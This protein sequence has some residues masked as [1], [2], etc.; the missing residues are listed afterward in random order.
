MFVDKEQGEIV[1][2]WT[3]NKKLPD[4]VNLQIVNAILRKCIIKS[5]SIGEELN[6]PPIVRLP[7]ASTKKP[8]DSRYIG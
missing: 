8:A 1:K 2:G 4:K 6:L 5:L 3:K 7:F